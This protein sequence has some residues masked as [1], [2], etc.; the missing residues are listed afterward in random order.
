MEEVE[1]RRHGLSHS[2]DVTGT[3]EESIAFS[4]DFR[5]SGEV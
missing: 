1:G 3:K 4:V 2:G 5:V